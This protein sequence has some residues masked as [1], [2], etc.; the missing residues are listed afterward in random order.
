[1]CNDTRLPKR[2]GQTEYMHSFH[3]IGVFV[4]KPNVVGRGYERCNISEGDKAAR[5]AARLSSSMFTI[6]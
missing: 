6:P 2:F 1:M 3:T 4:R 5:A